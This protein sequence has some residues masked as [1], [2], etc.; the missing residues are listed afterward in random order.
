MSFPYLSG[1]G[2]GDGEFIK[3]P[4]GRGGSEKERA[5]RF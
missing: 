2:R 5:S 4:R 1:E 3:F